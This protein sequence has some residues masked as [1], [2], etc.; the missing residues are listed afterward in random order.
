MSQ[1]EAVEA[2]Q[3]GTRLHCCKPSK[4]HLC[5]SPATLELVFTAVSVVLVKSFQAVGSLVV[6]PRVLLFPDKVDFSHRPISLLRNN[7]FRLPCILLLFFTTVIV[8]FTVN[9]HHKVGI[10]FNCA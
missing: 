6:E 3:R 7:Q 5:S 1:K 10:L 8:F 9:E 2:I 4:G